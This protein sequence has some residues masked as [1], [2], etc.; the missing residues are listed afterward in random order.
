MER[1]TGQKDRRAIETENGVEREQG[2][3]STYAGRAKRLGMGWGD[4]PLRVQT[5]R[6]K[7]GYKQVAGKYVDVNSVNHYCN[8]MMKANG[9]N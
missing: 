5:E 4:Q 7:K 8:N 6:M 3:T 9:I 2:C 1:Q